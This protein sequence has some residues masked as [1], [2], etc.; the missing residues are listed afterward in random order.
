MA[1]F[2]DKDRLMRHS[3]LLMAASQVGNLANLLF[4]AV[5]GRHLPTAEYGALSSMLGATII[6]SMPMDAIRAALAHFA[7][8]L[9]L[10]GRHGEVRL[11]AARWFR[12]LGIAALLP[13]LCIIAAS[14]SLASFWKLSGSAPVML[15][16]V[17]I[18]GMLLLP[19]YQGALQGIQAFIWMSVAQHSFAV[20][21]LVTTAMLLFYLPK[22]YATASTALAAQALAV[23]VALLLGWFGLRL[24]LRG[25]KPEGA[26]VEG[27]RSYTLQSLLVLACFAF[28]MNA[29]VLFVKRFF[30][31][32]TAG[33]FARAGTLGRIAVFLPMPI[34]A[35]LF[36]KV[37]GGAGNGRCL[38]ALIK[39]LAGSL[40]ILLAA[41]GFCSLW[42]QLPLG[43]VY[44]DW[45]PAREMVR[46]F[47]GLIWALTPL[48][49]TYV[50]INFEMAQKRFAACY[51]LAPCALAY[52]L[53]VVFFHK[54]PENVVA[55]L[56][57]T[58]LLSLLLLVGAVILRACVKPGRSGHGPASET[59]TTAPAHTP[60][61]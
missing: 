6:A 53:G 58:G 7:A 23:A 50:L 52:A 25:S 20:V 46:W 57:A 43:V 48:G 16:G 32:E 14:G 15:T 42:P 33:L 35:A 1:L 8:S 18:W 10:N 44:G 13:T 31:A 55:A 38:R 17:I 49:L 39:A 29:D 2:T 9:C 37:V 22:Q 61:A 34:A 12:R 28:I 27:F 24:L 47:R 45:Q 36:P 3:L 60:R 56:A 30:D 40:L 4:Q 21:R 41:A 26:K 5:A 19:V 54:T 59:H 51:A 11:L